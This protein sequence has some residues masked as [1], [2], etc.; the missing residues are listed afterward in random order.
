MT[1]ALLETLFTAATAVASPWLVGRLVVDLPGVLAGGRATGLVLAASVLVAVLVIAIVLGGFT[2]TLYQDLSLRTE[3]DVMI[4]LTRLCLSG[5]RIETLESPAFL[6]RIS[7]VRHRVWQID[8]GF[9][10]SLLTMN[11][12]LVL[13]GATISVG[14]LVG[15]GWAALLAAAA[16]GDSLLDARLGKWQQRAWNVSTE[17]ERHADYAFSLGGPSAAREVRLF[18]LSALVARRFWDQTTAALRPAWRRR[19]VAAGWQIAAMLVRTA[20]AMLAVLGV[21]GQAVRGELPIAAAAVA[22]PLVLQLAGVQVVGADRAAQGVAVLADLRATEQ[23]LDSSPVPR[24][25]MTTAPRHPSAPEKP[26]PAAVRFDDVSFRYPGRGEPVLDGLDLELRAGEQV[27][28]VGVNGAGKSTVI[29]LL[30]GGLRPQRGQ[31]VVDG[32]PLDGRDDAAVSR[33]QRQI[34]VLTQDFARYPMTVAGNIAAGAGLLD[35]EPGDPA[36]ARA[37]DLGAA[38]DV[39]RSLDRGWDTILDSRYTGGQDLSGGQWQRIGLARVARAVGAGARLVVLDEP[40]AALDTRS[41]DFL[42]RRHVALTGGVTSMIVS[43]RFSVLRPLPRIVVLDGGRIVEDGDHDS[44]MELD[45]QYARLF[46][47]QAARLIG[48]PA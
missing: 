41:E 31:V 44:L 35:G 8:Q 19:R 28:L 43:H 26:I 34:A 42:V 38:A 48:R 45:G 17:P 30:T 37:V 40:A 15:W 46:R 21:V 4:R 10:A 7:R 20:V 13:I 9:M 12:G 33:W 3:R 29:K 11:T 47:L 2:A 27:G 36:L 25:G 23:D 32:V 6:D 1:A 5:P 39:V 24:P 18:G 16:V 22:V 14:V